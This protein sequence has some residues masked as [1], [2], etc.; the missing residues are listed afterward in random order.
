MVGLH[1]YIDRESVAE[2]YLRQTLP[3]SERQTFEAHLVD[4]QEC[5]DRLLL[6]EM[7]Q[8][9]AVPAAVLQPLAPLRVRMVAAL[10]HWQL[11]IL[12][13]MAVL[14]LLAI[15]S[16]AFLWELNRLGGPR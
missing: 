16:L 2:R 12:A 6:A 3:A 8:R 14:A 15:P 11:A 7:F 9:A 10:S 13:C 4:C 1:G 5:A